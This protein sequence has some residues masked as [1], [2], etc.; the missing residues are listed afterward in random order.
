MSKK[1]RQGSNFSPDANEVENQ[2][3]EEEVM[4]EELRIDVG[5]VNDA[6]AIANDAEIEVATETPAVEITIEDVH[7]A[8]DNVAKQVIPLVTPVVE[9][10]KEDLKVEEKGGELKLDIAKPEPAKEEEAPA[11]GGELSV[12]DMVIIVPDVEKDVFGVRLGGSAYAAKYT[13]DRLQGKDKVVIKSSVSRFTFKK[14]QV[15]KV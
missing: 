2:N 10:K 13:V 9:E 4:D 11:V 1:R 8:V 6:P 3:M 5:E 14:D 15:R 12:G 7:S